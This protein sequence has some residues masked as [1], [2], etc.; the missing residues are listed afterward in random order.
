[1]DTNKDLFYPQPN[2]VSQNYWFPLLLY[3]TLKSIKVCPSFFVQSAVKRLLWLPIFVRV[4][5][6]IDL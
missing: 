5:H 1:M 3:S 6:G 4:T 2:A